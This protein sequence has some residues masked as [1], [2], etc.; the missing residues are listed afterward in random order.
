M[1]NPRQ[2]CWIVVGT[3]SVAACAANAQ[4]CQWSPLGLGL[5]EGFDPTARVM[6]VV[7]LGDGPALYVGGMFQMAGGRIAYGV[8]RWDGEDWSDLDGGLWFAGASALAG[9]DDGTG[10][11]LYAAGD[12][13]EAGGRPAERIA[14]W[15]PAGGW[16]TV[17]GGF[18]PADGSGTALEV[19]DDGAGEALYVAGLVT[20]V[21]GVPVS[22]IARW[23]G[24]QW[25][26]VG[27][28][29]DGVI[30]DM[31][32]YDDGTGPALY[33]AGRFSL[34][35]GVPVRNIARWDGSAWSA[36]GLGL[37]SLDGRPQITTLTVY[38]DGDG[39]AL[40]AA[41]RFDAIGGGAAEPFTNIARW[42]GSAWSPLGA[43]VTTWSRTLAA[44]Q[45]MAVHDPGDG[46]RLYV[47]GYLNGAG[48]QPVNSLAVWDGEAWSPVGDGLDL[49]VFALARYDQGDG[50]SLF[51]G[52]AF[53]QVDGVEVN[54]IAR[55]E[56]CV[57]AC[58]ADLLPD[59]EL[60]L[61]DFLVFQN[62]FDAGDPAADFDGDG[63]LTI[64]DFLVFQN[65]FV[66]GC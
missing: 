13:F 10:P 30:L 40:Y 56:G 4:E 44:V 59:G 6:E 12:F 14:R 53:T 57:Q 3:V 37:I 66:A 35:G 21:G 63:R 24:A 17:G 32:V 2:A 22:G 46:A 29:V 15:T 65:E 48:G 31:A 20:S 25:S 45:A 51:A 9:Y 1:S 49:G 34:A 5:T 18:N 33:A 38:D 41:G 52:G 64:F 55:L 19:F 54:H 43:G 50:P 7:D 16:Q 39:P 28:G 27:G 11:A 8:A 58:R 61:F 23:D 62:L 26:D 42:D 47:G 36:V 60:N